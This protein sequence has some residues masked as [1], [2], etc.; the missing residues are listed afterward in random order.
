MQGEISCIPFLGYAKV[1]GIGVP[2]FSCPLIL[3]TGIGT[4]LYDR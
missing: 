3:P 1:Q 2:F 4:G